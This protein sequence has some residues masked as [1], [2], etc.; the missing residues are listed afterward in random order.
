MGYNLLVKKRNWSDTY[1]VVNDISHD[2][3]RA[4]A[5]EIKATN[6]CTDPDI[7]TLERQ[8]QTIASRVPHSYA[9]CLEHRLILKAMSVSYGFS[10]LWIT[11][12]PSD[13][14]CPLVL[15]LAGVSLPT[16]IDQTAF[17]KM[18]DHTAIMNPVAVAQFFH[19]TCVAIMDHLMASGRQDGLLGPI[20]HHYGVVETNG[21]GMLHLHCML[22]LSGNLGLADLRT[23]LLEDENYATRMITYLDTII[24]CCVDE[25]ILQTPTSSSDQCISPTARGCESDSD[26]LESINHDSN[27]VAAVK[28]MHS[29]SHNATCFK[30]AHGKDRRCRFDFPRPLINASFVGQHGV[31][32]LKR[33]NSWINPWNPVLSSL[34]R[35][36]HDIN[37]LPT[38]MKALAI[39]H[40]ITNYATKGDCSQYQRIMSA[41]IVRKAYE[42][43]QS[44]AT[45]TGSSLPVRHA[46][47]DKFALRTFN[48]L[49]YEREVSGPLAASCLLDLPDHYSHDISLRRINLN[50]LRSRF[51]SIIFHGSTIL[52]SSDDDATFTGFVQPPA[53]MFEHYRCRGIH[54]SEFCL[55]AYFA[56]IS[57]VRRKGSSGQLFEF[58][59]SYPHK[60][61]LIQKHHTKPGSEFLVA[62]I[63][64]LSQCQSEEDAVPGGHRDTI[65][66]QDD[67]ADA[68]PGGHPDTISRQDDLAEILLALFIPWQH[69]P[70]IFI[71]ADPTTYKKC[72]WNLWSKYE[73]F[74][75]PYIKALA[76]NVWN[77]QKSK[78]DV[79]L[80]MATRQA[81][82]EASQSIEVDGLLEMPEEEPDTGDQSDDDEFGSL[83]TLEES[84]SLVLRQ[85]RLDDT[86]DL[87][88]IPAVRPVGTDRICSSSLPFRPET[89]APLGPDQLLGMTSDFIFPDDDT[90]SDW[91]TM[92]KQVA[93]NVLEQQAQQV[94]PDRT[95]EHCNY[96]SE[97]TLL[98]SLD[99]MHHETWS[100]DRAR[101]L[102]GT[103]PTSNG[104][105]DIVSAHLPLNQRQEIIVREVMRHTMYN[106][107][108]PR[109]ERS[110]QLLLVVRG[111]GG[112][113]KSQVI[114]AIYRAYDVVGKVD[115]IFITAPTGAAADNIS[116]S[117][118]HTALGI[119][120]RKTKESIKG[121]QKLE[122]LW[123]NKTAIIVDEMSMVSLDFLATVDLHLGRAKS[124][125]E[126]SSAVLGGLSVVI[127]LGDFFQFSPVTGRSL[128]EVPLS[129][130]E[131]HGQHIWHHFTDIITLT[132]QMRQQGD[133]VFQQLLKRARTG[134][135]TQEDVDLLNSKVAEELPT[136]ND[137]SSVVVVQTNA[138][139]HLINRHQIYVMAREKS[140]DVYIFPASH[141]RSKIRGGNLVS[142]K[143]LFRVQDGGTITGPGLLYYTEG[144]PTAV[145]SN[146]CTLLGLVNRARYQ[147]IGIVPDDN[148]MFNFP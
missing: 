2:R 105:V 144:M 123:R 141:T 72:C 143:K 77:L 78:M 52:Q 19:I 111:E 74:L 16:A 108:T 37:F 43:A 70:G 24:S 89:F 94:D 17:R 39:I 27:A 134:R 40:Y 82:A 81:N 98:P 3:L 29:S 5:T 33:N 47:L 44:K 20:S 69:L 63:G 62:L 148:G 127:F 91:V 109:P 130:H 102:A 36:N 64:T 14:R 68:V 93:K 58:E 57:V 80:D 90:I 18:Q 61:K 23:R 71:N 97:I 4:A 7:V 84:I 56:T 38:K 65:S 85:W 49:A 59:E 13:L 132:K 35:S 128:W 22:W 110:D 41:A 12:N 146:V 66:R 113:G 131:E 21:R 121:Q 6:K 95:T 106:Q 136:S 26:W 53:C 25:A 122:K 107:A 92:Q 138:K 142:G 83:K 101:S 75:P 126:N 42:D 137:L 96:N 116:G 73:R 15:V 32:E 48:R 129:S 100:I 54:L 115:Q 50:L 55:Y 114:K 120:T 86:N 76:A 133:I 147:A 117:T 34:I 10:A 88:Q 124:L 140:Q 79:A 9:R 125:H 135:L 99:S 46:D 60:L 103:D 139:R 8:V 145:L 104:V 119:D 112:V 28:Q 67:L 31:I 45:A 87:V 51:V 11:V 1:K 118:L 30:Y